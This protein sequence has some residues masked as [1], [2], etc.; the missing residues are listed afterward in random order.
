M[1]GAACLVAV[2]VMLLAGCGGGISGQAGGAT[3]G[4]QEGTLQVFAAASLTDAFKEMATKFEEQN[5][6]VEVRTSFA[7]SSAV[8]AQIQQGAPADV[9]ASADKEK[10]DTAVGDGLVEEP[11]TFVKNAEVVTV[12]NDNPAGIQELQDLA[13]DDV[14]FVLAQEDVPVADYAVDVLGNATPALGDNFEQDVMDNLVSREAD[15]RAAINRVALGEADATFSYS[16]DVTPDIRDQ[17]KIVEIPEKFNVIPTYPIASLKDAKN[18]ELAR[19]WVEFVTS[20]EG[21]GVLEK[22]GFQPVSQ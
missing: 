18:P 15:T 11:R 22:W 17:V 6:G 16:S 7:S 5:P 8:L 3:G 12:P 20:G 10:M 21:Q 2:V 4:G 1:S 14:D 9:F 13:Q 19:R